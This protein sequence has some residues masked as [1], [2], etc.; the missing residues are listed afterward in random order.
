MDSSCVRPA[1]GAAGANKE[2]PGPAASRPR[3]SRRRRGGFGTKS[4]AVVTP[5][6]HPVVLERTGS[7]AADSPRR[8]GLIA[9]RTTD[10]V[11]A[12]RGYESDA[13]RAARRAPG[14]GPCIPPRK[15]RKSPAAYD[16]HLD[17]ERNV[18]ERYFARVQQYR[19]VATRYDKRAAN[20]LGF[21]WVA[22]I[23]IMLA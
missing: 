4:H 10:A 11:L 7:E 2:R 19:R 8:P 20:Y 1:A 22:S 14:A 18:A 5:L 23:E 15:N 3:R 21:V 17:K 6:G 13:N 12:G 9:G 16:R